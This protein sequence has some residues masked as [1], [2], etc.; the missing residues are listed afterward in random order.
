[1]RITHHRTEVVRVSCS[2]VSGKIALV[3]CLTAGIGAEMDRLCYSQ[4]SALIKLR[5]QFA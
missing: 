4:H 2:W 5:L 1:M 3:N